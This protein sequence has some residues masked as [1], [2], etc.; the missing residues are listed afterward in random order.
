M[1]KITISFN[2]TIF[3]PFSALSAA[4]LCELAIFFMKLATSAKVL[5]CV[6]IKKGKDLF[7]NFIVISFVRLLKTLPYYDGRALFTKLSSFSG[8]ALI[9]C[10]IVQ[11][12][13]MLTLLA[14][15]LPNK[16]EYNWEAAAIHP[17]QGSL[18]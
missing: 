9:Y 4:R 2:M 18:F 1:A 3:T 5:W 16:I 6:F 11:F 14:V 13:L 8:K 10:E 15:L 7:Y 17:L 12:L